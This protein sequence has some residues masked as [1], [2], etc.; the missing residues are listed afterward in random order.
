MSTD[1]DA[2]KWRLKEA[3]WLLRNLCVRTESGELVPVLIE[4]EEGVFTCNPLA[5]KVASNQPTLRAH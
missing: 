1:G 3:D 5:K 2:E 4:T